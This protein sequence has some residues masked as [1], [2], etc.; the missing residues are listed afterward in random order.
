MPG[1]CRLDDFMPA[2]QFNEVHARRIAATPDRVYAAIRAL[3]AREIRGFRLLTWLR[4]F[5]RAMPPHILHVPDGMPVLDA[6][7]AGGGVLLA[8][9]PPREIVFGLVVIGRDRLPRPMTPEGFRT[10]SDPGLA[11]AAMNFLIEP[12]AQGGSLVSTETRVHATDRN[13]TRRF[14]VYWRIIQP[15]SALIRRMWLR[16]IDRRATR[17]PD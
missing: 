4:R 5:G 3:E 17:A 8:D 14:G 13:S 9:A 1:P 7:L 15:W 6:A 2:W 12:D 11:K 10:A 16:A